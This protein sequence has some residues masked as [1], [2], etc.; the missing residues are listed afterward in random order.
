[1]EECDN[2]ND[3]AGSSSSSSSFEDTVWQGFENTTNSC[4]FAAAIVGLST[5]PVF[6][7]NNYRANSKFSLKCTK[8]LLESSCSALK[9]CFEKIIGRT[10][11]ILKE[12][13]PK[14][15]VGTFCSLLKSRQIKPSEHN[16]VG[17]A[18]IL[19][20]HIF[21]TASAEGQLN[22]TIACK[23]C[24]TISSVV[25]ECDALLF[26]VP[27]PLRIRVTFCYRLG[28][29]VEFYLSAELSW[30]VAQLRDVILEQE[31][32][33]FADFSA[34]LYSLYFADSLLVAI[35]DN[36]I[37][38]GECLD[39][40]CCVFF[41]FD[42]SSAFVVPEQKEIEIVKFS[43]EIQCCIDKMFLESE[44]TGHCGQCDLT[45]KKSICSIVRHPKS[46][47]LTI[48]NLA[49]RT[50]NKY[51]EG[52][53]SAL[54]PLTLL[55]GSMSLASTV[56][57]SGVRY[58]LCAVTYVIANNSMSGHC[59]TVRCCPDHRWRLYD[60]K[61]VTEVELSDVLN[62]GV[63]RKYAKCRPEV[64]YFNIIEKTDGYDSANNSFSSSAITTEDEDFLQYQ[65]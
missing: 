31:E 53:S 39:E 10:N 5:L 18:V 8:S 17:E 48:Q 12:F 24:S 22:T 26:T 1:M 28:M 9:I 19:L 60:D 34:D 40:S 20:L 7:N 16:S 23:N 54:T 32:L 21:D 58:M 63:E 49:C 50:H 62:R 44:R 33:K 30:T 4:W 11:R 41:V 35:Y 43:C 59:I 65:G 51:G 61:E 27:V 3:S 29:Y 2:D 46:L 57:F 25:K 56:T 15:V 45:I 37:L 42:D 38:I 64:L 52:E 13:D 14:F 55:P 47:I 36:D 6:I